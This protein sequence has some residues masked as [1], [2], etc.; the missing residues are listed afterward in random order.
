[1]QGWYIGMTA[2][3][4]AVKAGSTPV[5]CSMKREYPQRVLFFRGEGRCI[6]AERS[7]ASCLVHRSNLQNIVTKRCRGTRV[8]AKWADSRTLLH[9]KRVPTWSSQIRQYKKREAT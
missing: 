9:E 5:P 4:Q 3:S 1:M 6:R 2:A 8:K 7:S